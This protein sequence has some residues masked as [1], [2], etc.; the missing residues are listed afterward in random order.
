MTDVGGFLASPTHD[1]VDDSGKVVDGDLLNGPSPIA[2]IRTREV[3]VR[4]LEVGAD[5]TEVHIVA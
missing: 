3:T 2:R 4:H 5:V 1:K